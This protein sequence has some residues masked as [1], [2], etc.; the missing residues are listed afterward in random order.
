MSDYRRV[1]V[2]G[3]TYFFTVVTAERR[4]WLATHDGL[5]A[6]RRS[7]SRVARDAPFTTLAAVV[8]PDH[9]HAVWRLPPGDADFPGRWQRIKRRTVERLRRRGWPGPFW[10]ARF[11]ERLIRDEDDLQI[12]M[13]YVHYNPVRHGL[14]ERAAEW[15]ASS[16]HR[17]IRAG[18]Y[19]PDWGVVDPA[20]VERAVLGPG[21]DP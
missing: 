18:W 14:V 2:P 5:D 13:D 4:P 15:R 8:L 17:Y 6:F 1:H 7:W 12:H 16:V 19:T 21:G 10:Q 9:V 3:G 11:W 20:A